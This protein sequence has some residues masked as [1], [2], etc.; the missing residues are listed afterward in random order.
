L[1]LLKNY[2]NPLEREVL[3]GVQELIDSVFLK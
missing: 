2:L 1:K 3:L